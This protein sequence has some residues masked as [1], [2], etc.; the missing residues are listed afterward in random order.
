[1][2]CSKLSAKPQQAIDMTELFVPAKR[3]A[4]SQAH[5]YLKARI[6]SLFKK[7]LPA[8]VTS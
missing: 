7:M 2:L 8:V 6:L 1:M 5:P 3:C 4:F